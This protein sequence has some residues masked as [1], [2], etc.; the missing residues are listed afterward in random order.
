MTSRPDG[1]EVCTMRTLLVAALLATAVAVPGRA[2]AQ[3]ALSVRL[4]YALGRGEVVTG[5]HLADYVDASIPVQ[6]DATWRFGLLAAGA[7]VS[8]ADDYAGPVLKDKCSGTGGSTCSSAGTRAGALLAWTFETGP[9]H[10]WAA[11]GLG[12]EWLQLDLGNGKGSFSGPEGSAQAGLDFAVAP[13]I[14]LGP[15]ASASL[16]RY[17]GS[18]GLA[19]LKSGQAWHEWYTFGIRARFD[20][21]L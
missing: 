7:Y 20:L 17:T 11:V 6:L 15:W 2:A 14:G 1:A 12:W 9:V 21:D 3:L 10:P 18:T 5:A 13:F 16:G 4:G 19:T 8:Y